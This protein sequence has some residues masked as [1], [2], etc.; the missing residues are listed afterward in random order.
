MFLNSFMSQITC[1]KYFKACLKAMPLRD[2][3]G[4][5]SPANLLFECTLCSQFLTREILMNLNVWKLRNHFTLS[6]CSHS[7]RWRWIKT[8]IFWWNTSVEIWR[9]YLSVSVIL[10]VLTDCCSSIGQS[11]ILRNV[12]EDSLD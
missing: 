12:V 2:E 9:R 1:P 10:L 6:Y 4:R 7:L 5:I 8:F 3:R 11:S